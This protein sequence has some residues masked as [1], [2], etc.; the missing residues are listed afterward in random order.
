[1][2]SEFFDPSLNHLRG[3]FQQ[4][5]LVLFSLLGKLLVT[6]LD[7][8]SCLLASLVLVGAKAKSEAHNSLEG[9]YASILGRLLFDIGIDE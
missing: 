4:L 3:A 7:V 6:E 9:S 8:G 1:M 5:L 2:S